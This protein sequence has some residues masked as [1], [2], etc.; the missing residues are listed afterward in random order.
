MYVSSL[1]FLLLSLEFA[2]SSGEV[3]LLLL[4]L[5]LETAYFY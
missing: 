2:L 4:L 5:G 3:E 1:L